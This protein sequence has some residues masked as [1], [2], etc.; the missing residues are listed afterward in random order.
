MISSY[1]CNNKRNN[2]NNVWNADILK[3]LNDFKNKT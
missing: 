1:V 2:N 3:D